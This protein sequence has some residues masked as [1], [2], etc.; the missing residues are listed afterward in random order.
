M[1]IESG[2]KSSLRRRPFHAKCCSLRGVSVA[3]RILSPIGGGVIIT[4][5]AIFMLKLFWTVYAR[6]YLCMIYIGYSYKFT[7]S[8]R[9]FSRFAAMGGWKLEA[10]RFTILVAFPVFS[11][12]AFNQP[13]IF[14]FFVCLHSCFNSFTHLGAYNSQM[15]TYKPPVVDE[16]SRRKVVEWKATLAE[17]RR[18]RD[19]ESFLQQEMAFEEARRARERANV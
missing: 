18:K 9:Y 6:V 19:Q 10:T 2:S 4:T 1:S 13:D 17:N 15:S 11:F 12:W 14:N 8:N 16:E 5:T 7:S 3:S